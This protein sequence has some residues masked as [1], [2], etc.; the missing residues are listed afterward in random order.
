[1]L[2]LR[3]CYPNTLKKEQRMQK[4]TRKKSTGMVCTTQGSLQSKQRCK[5]YLPWRQFTLGKC[6]AGARVSV[7]GST[8]MLL[9]EE[10]GRCHDG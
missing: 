8:V 2:R 7:W 1:M 9:Q 5:A 10:L 6:S 4:G 3:N